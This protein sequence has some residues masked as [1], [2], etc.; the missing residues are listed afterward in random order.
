MAFLESTAGT[1]LDTNTLNFIVDGIKDVIGI[2]TTPPLG[3]F[4][5]IGIVGSIVGLTMGIVSRVKNV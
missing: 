2:F 4:L 3:I 5:T 1:V